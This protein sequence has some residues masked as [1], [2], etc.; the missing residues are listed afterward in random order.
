MWNCIAPVP[1]RIQDSAP[2]EYSIRQAGGCQ[3]TYCAATAAAAAAG[4][5]AAFFRGFLLAVFFAA[6]FFATAGLSAAF[7]AWN[8]AQR[9]FVASTIARLPAALSL[10]LR[11]GASDAAAGCAIPLDSAHRFRCASPMRFRAAALIFRRFTFGASVGAGS[12]RPPSSICRISTICSSIRR[13]CA[14][15]PSMAAIRISAVSFC[16]CPPQLPP[17][18]QFHGCAIKRVLAMTSS[19]VATVLSLVQPVI[20]KECQAPSVRAVSRA[21]CPRRSTSRRARTSPAHRRSS[22]HLPPR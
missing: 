20:P 3:A 18:V 15:K 8:A 12:G 13:F 2:P 10:R 4:G 9:F 17:L 1:V 14:S 16:V 22:P 21:F 11:F 7:P 19:S 5:F 6:A